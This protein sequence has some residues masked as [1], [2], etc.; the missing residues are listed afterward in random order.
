[1][2]EAVHTTTTAAVQST[3]PRAMCTQRGQ[4]RQ[5]ARHASKSS[6]PIL[7]LA[8]TFSLGSCPGAPVR[9]QTVADSPSVEGVGVGVGKP[10]AGL[11][12]L[13]ATS[14]RKTTRPRDFGAILY[15]RK[16]TKSGL[17]PQQRP[18]DR[19]LPVVTA[20]RVDSS[21]RSAGGR[22]L[23]VPPADLSE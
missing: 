5:T 23:L 9:A 17:D 16:C 3:L 4:I 6:N 15:E 18:S 20:E 19:Q 14:W 21:A 8:S 13:R 1:M 12:T 2:K 11:N 7:Y 10:D 22:R